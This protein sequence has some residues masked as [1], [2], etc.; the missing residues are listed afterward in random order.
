M[1]IHYFH[2]KSAVPGEFMNEPCHAQCELI[3]ILNDKIFQF[4]PLVFH[5]VC[6]AA[7]SVYGKR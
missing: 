4:I 5:T 1:T 3:P 6:T 7:R 2:Y